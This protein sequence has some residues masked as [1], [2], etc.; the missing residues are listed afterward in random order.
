MRRYLLIVLPLIFLVGF[1][2][3]AKYKKLEEKNIKQQKTINGMNQEIETLN[4]ELGIL[5]KSREELIAAKQ[6]LEKELKTELSAGDLQLVLKERGLVITVLNKVL[7]A[8]GKAKLKTS[9][10]D[11][12]N[13]VAGILKGK[14]PNNIVYVEGHTDN[15]PITR[16]SWKSNWE[17]STARA[18]EVLHYLVEKGVNAS[19]M[20]VCGY[21]EYSPVA[22][23]ASIEGRKKN[24]RVEIIISPKKL[25][26]LLP[27]ESV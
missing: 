3:C 1:S 19:R 13:K 8:S 5:A 23:N 14:V 22:D 17:L 2:G 9:S 25:Q 6:D 7:F 24:R 4:K 18:L 27:K 11:T 20:V 21:G 10:K 12:L 26:E 16:S 15:V